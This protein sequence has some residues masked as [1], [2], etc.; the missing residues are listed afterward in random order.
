MAF[1][2]LFQM[3]DWGCEEQVNARDRKFL[4]TPNS[5]IRVTGFG[6]MTR[7][8]VGSKLVLSSVTMV[9]NGLPCCSPFSKGAQCG[10]TLMQIRLKNELFSSFAGNLYKLLLNW[11]QACRR[12]GGVDGGN[13]DLCLMDKKI[14]KNYQTGP[15]CQCFFWRLL[16]LSLPATSLSSPGASGDR[17]CQPGSP[18]PAPGLR[19]PPWGFGWC[20]CRVPSGS[21]AI[22]PRDPWYSPNACFWFWWKR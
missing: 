16:L 18:T 3:A 17:A 19:Y 7:S 11:Q 8:W 10:C 2:L 9:R 5:C 21:V 22:N 13:K 20:S 14:H 1:L 15:G 4:V 12:G 6:S